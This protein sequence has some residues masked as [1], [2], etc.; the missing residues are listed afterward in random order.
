MFISVGPRVEGHEH[1]QLGRTSPRSWAGRCRPLTCRKSL[2][3]TLLHLCFPLCLLGVQLPCLH[4]HQ[5]SL[6]WAILDG[7]ASLD[8]IVHM[9]TPYLPNSTQQL[10]CSHS[11][12]STIRAC[13]AC[14]EWVIYENK[15][16]KWCDDFK[17]TVSIVEMES[18]IGLQARLFETH[19]LK[20]DKQGSISRMISCNVLSS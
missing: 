3:P 12:W 2:R 18:H 10:N 20:V 15:H 8:C 4:F 16:T 19:Q 7:R 1:C 11:T 13:T 17:D 5:T 6:P 9:R 14:N